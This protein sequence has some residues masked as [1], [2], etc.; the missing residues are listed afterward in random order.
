MYDNGPFPV[1]TLDLGR[2][3][4]HARQRLAGLL[5]VALVALGLSTGVQTALAP[6]AFAGTVSVQLTQATVDA[7]T[8]T[9][10]VN[11]QCS[12]LGSPCGF[13][14]ITI[15]IPSPATVDSIG[16]LPPGWTIS[17][18]GS[19][20]LLQKPNFGDG[21]TLQLTLT[22]TGGPGTY[23]TTI[24]SSSSGAGPSSSQP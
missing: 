19:Q 5:A 21:E 14:T 7:N 12:G 17:Q 18:S 9:W 20:I 6:S 13:T 24:S 8:W 16:A 23:C 1:T 2:I 4:R 3:A 10:T 22:L 15:P 11:A